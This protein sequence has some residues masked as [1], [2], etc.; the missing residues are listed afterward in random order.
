[1]SR[2]KSAKSN[3]RKG[4][5]LT[6][7]KGST[8]STR[9]LTQK[10]RTAKGRKLSSTK[11]L[12]RQLNDPYVMEARMRGYRSRAAFKL[13]QL[14]D[15]FNLLSPGQRVVDLGAAP[16]GWTQVAVER[17]LANNH[18]GHAGK[19]FGVDI[20][21]I[22]PIEG[23][24]LVKYDVL[25]PDI[26]NNFIPMLNGYV[27]VVLSDMAAPS[28]GHQ[29]TDH[30]RIMD[31]CNTA[32]NS[33]KSILLPGGTFVAKVLQGGTEASLL[34]DIKTS[35]KLVKHA[36]PPASRS[37]SAEMYLVAKDFIGNQSHS[38]AS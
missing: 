18:S 38:Q 26:E 20:C 4:K 31:L 13:I 15:K 11:W 33:A 23:A 5:N 1:M 28:S 30:I 29:K 34:K 37:N 10:V 6:N 7:N 17:V 21:T 27:D 12:N 32:F 24:T 3:L 16:G 8:L 14:D 19:V 2:S 36:K 25:N 9:T 22:E 35:F